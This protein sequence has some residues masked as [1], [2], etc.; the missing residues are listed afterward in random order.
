ME[1]QSNN[2]TSSKVPP[3]EGFREAFTLHLADSALILGHRNSEWCGHGPILEQDIAITN[4][5]LDLIGQARNFYQYAATMVNAQKVSTPI[6]GRNSEGAITEDS[7]AYFRNSPE[8]KNILLVELPKGDWAQTILRQFFFS[9]WQNLLFEKLKESNDEQIS[10]IVTKALKEIA[11][12]LRWSSEWVIRLGDGTDES[13]LRMEKALAE[14]WSYTEEMFIP[15]NYELE[16]LNNGTG[17][18]VT[19]L[20]EGWLENAEKVFGEAGLIVPSASTINTGGKEGKHT[21]HLDEILK[22]LQSV[23]RA[24]PTATW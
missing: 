12:H 15:V 3:L 14:L 16:M 2:K 7:F 18:D 13:R 23:A 6:D 1:R 19:L 10:A 22:E 21:V 4:I 8:F 20:K 11:Y 5:S 24:H 9:S 17:A